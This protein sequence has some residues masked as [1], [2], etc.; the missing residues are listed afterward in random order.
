MAFKTKTARLLCIIIFICAVFA[1]AVYAEDFDFPNGL[2]HYDP[3][4]CSEGYTLVPYEAGMILLVDMKG[5]V[6]HKW[7]IGTERARL[8]ENG[9]IVVMQLN[10]ARE[11]DWEGKLVWEYTLPVGPGE[12]RGY[13]TPGLLHHDMQRL[14]NGNTI[15]LYHDLVPAEYRQLCNHPERREAEIIGDCVC[16]VNKAGEIIWEWHNYKHLD[17][18]D[19]PEG[20]PPDD[21]DWTH[22]NTVTILPLNKWY[23]QGHQEFKPGNVLVCSRHLD[24]IYIIDKDTKEIVWSYSGKYLWG[25]ARPHEPYMI[26]PG[27]PGAGNILIFDNGSEK[28][29][30]AKMET[31]VVLEINPVSKQIVWMYDNGSD[32]YSA[33]QG[34]QQRMPNGNTLICESTQGR[35]FEVTYAGEI[36][37]E[38]VMPPFPGS[39]AEH[40]FGTR[41]HRYPYDYCPQM[42]KLQKAEEKD[43]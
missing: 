9:N 11:Y 23:M 17:L 42:K 34:T 28:K 29:H 31:S 35:I 10:N 2:R 25:L 33:I 1:S 30:R 24:K 21:I 15:F 27:M 41:P 18:N 4:E 12:G 3:G 7:D 14:P 37:W 38:Y 5:E 40:G 32:F 20:A 8:L 19:Q 6:V 26:K 39:D 36:V 13:P 43:N 22:M 16:E